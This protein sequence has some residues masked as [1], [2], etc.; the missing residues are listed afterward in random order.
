WICCVAL[1]PRL[2]FGLV[3]RERDVPHE[4]EAQARVEHRATF[5]PPRHRAN[6][7]DIARAIPAKSQASAT[8]TRL[9]KK[10]APSPT[11]VRRVLLVVLQL[12]PSATYLFHQTPCEQTTPRLTDCP[13]IARARKLPRSLNTRTAAPS[14]MPRDP[15][16]SAWMWT[17]GS[18]A[19]SRSAG[20]LTK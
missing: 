7:V 3:S 20:R 13:T 10:V 12:A 11:S 2:R 9:S 17:V 5:V 14:A 19:C 15:A 8:S 4:P 1:D 16:S 6:W 18:P